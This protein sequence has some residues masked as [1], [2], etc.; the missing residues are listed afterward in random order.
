MC[1]NYMVHITLIFNWNYWIIIK[2]SLKLIKEVV[3]LNKNTIND[4]L[5]LGKMEEG[6][7]IRAQSNA[8]CLNEFLANVTKS[9]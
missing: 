1:P 9:F 3:E 2:E 8:I 7:Q 5:D 4:L 6:I